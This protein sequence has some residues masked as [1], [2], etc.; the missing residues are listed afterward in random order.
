MPNLRLLSFS[1][2]KSSQVTFLLTRTVPK[3]SELLKTYRS[4]TNLLC[5]LKGSSSFS[6]AAEAHSGDCRSCRPR[7]PQGQFMSSDFS[8]KTSSLLLPEPEKLRT[9]NPHLQQAPSKAV[10]AGLEEGHEPILLVWLCARSRG[11][12]CRSNSNFPVAQQP[13]R[14][15]G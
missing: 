4:K 14:A 7:K 11:W 12:L 8:R 6:G 13:E 1:M 10:L 15:S 2:E 3:Y 5:S 9:A